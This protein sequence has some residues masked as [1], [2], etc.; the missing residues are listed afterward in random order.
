MAAIMLVEAAAECFK[1]LL[2]LPLRGELEVEELEVAI[3]LLL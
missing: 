3:L 1:Y 2:R